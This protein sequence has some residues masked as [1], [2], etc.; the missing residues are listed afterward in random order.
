MTKKSKEDRPV[1]I[2]NNLPFDKFID[3]YAK[4]EDVYFKCVSTSVCAITDAEA[5]AHSR[6]AYVI[7]NLT[8]KVKNL[9]I[10]FKDR[11]I[12]DLF[13]FRNCTFITFGDI[14]ATFITLEAET[15]AEFV[16]C[17]FNAA[18]RT[19]FTVEPFGDLN[20]TRSS[21][22]TLLVQGLANSDIR[23]DSCDIVRFYAMSSENLHFV[24][25]LP[26]NADIDQ[27]T[28]VSIS[29]VDEYP[30]HPVGSRPVLTVKNGTQTLRPHIE[31]DKG[32]RGRR[33][34]FL[35]YG[36]TGDKAF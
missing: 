15:K 34:R 21:S 30:Q 5:K 27:T 25:K 35:R 36:A 33:G 10:G 18:D 6:P 20:I 29:Y 3:K 26:Y 2:D 19:C 1:S 23:I 32:L 8:L 13:V 17:S 31:E 28:S 4:R 7:E 11:S 12:P 9:S 16:D 14:D 22:H 24:S